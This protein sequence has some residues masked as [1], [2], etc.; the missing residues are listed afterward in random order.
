MPTSTNTVSFDA[1]LILSTGR[2]YTTNIYELCNDGNRSNS[3]DDTNTNANVY[4]TSNACRHV[5]FAGLWDTQSAL[6]AK[7]TTTIFKTKYKNWHKHQQTTT[8]TLHGQNNG[9]EI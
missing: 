3:N 4:K 5:P 8:R 6:M 1:T 7:F 2:C 9:P